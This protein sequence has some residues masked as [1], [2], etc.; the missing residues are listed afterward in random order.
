MRKPRQ[1]GEQPDGAFEGA[2][3]VSRGFDG[4][5]LNPERQLGVR[6][7]ARW[8]CIRAVGHPQPTRAA[9][10]RRK[11]LPE[12]PPSAY[13][14]AQARHTPPAARRLFHIASDDEGPDG[15]PEE[16]DEIDDDEL[17]APDDALEARTR[18]AQT[19]AHAL[20]ELLATEAGYLADLRALVHVY[21]AQLPTLTAR[22]PLNLPILSP[23]YS[24]SFFP[25]KPPKPAPASPTDPFS[26]AAAPA[27][28]RSP[29]A[30]SPKSDDPGPPSRL[31]E[32]DRLLAD[33]D[34]RTVARNAAQILAV[35]D[36][37][38]RMLSG[39]AAGV[40]VADAPD[41]IERAIVGVATLF[42]T[43]AALFNAYE[44]FCVGHFDAL[45]SVRRVQ[46]RHPAEWDAY[47]RRCAVLVRDMQERE[48]EEAVADEK[49]D[50][51][52]VGEGGGDVD[53][54]AQ[55]GAGVH[56]AGSTSSSS[57][58]GTSAYT[59]TQDSHDAPAPTPAP[60]LLTPTSAPPTKTSFSASPPAERPATPTL[61]KALY[62][63]KERA[64]DKP[65]RRLRRHSMGAL[66][67]RMR[68]ARSLKADAVAAA[69][70]LP[71]PPPQPRR[72]ST[73][74]RRAQGA[75]LQFMDYLIKPVQRICK[76]P[77][78]L[79]LLYASPKGQEREV[80]GADVVV[81]SAAQAMRHV[82]ALVD[83]AHAQHAQHTQSARV[84]AR[85]SLPASFSPPSPAS[86]PADAD[87]L[88]FARGA[89]P[90]RLAGALDVLAARG[91]RGVARG[92]VRAR[93]L[94][95]VL[96]DGGWC[97]LVKAVRGRYE[98]RHWFEVGKFAVH[99]AVDEDPFL[100]YSIR[101]YSA[102]GDFELA[103]ACAGEKRL[104]LAALLDA[105]KVEN[106]P[107]WAGTA[108]CSLGFG[109]PD[110]AISPV[111]DAPSMQI[112]PSLPTI[113]SIPEL[114]GAPCLPPVSA[115]LDLP[116][117]PPPP[118]TTTPIPPT[119]PAFKT[120][121]SS[122]LSMSARTLG[123]PPSRRSSAVS[124]RAFFNGADVEDGAVEVHRSALLARAEVDSA[125]A[126]VVSG[127]CSAARCWAEA[128]DE[129]LFM[130][131]WGVTTVRS[132][133][134]A[135]RSRLARR[136]SL[137]VRRRRSNVDLTAA[138]PLLEGLPVPAGGLLAGHATIRAPRTNAKW[139]KGKAALKVV[140]GGE[141]HEEAV[142]IVDPV[143]EAASAG[144]LVVVQSPDALLLPESPTLVSQCSSTTASHTGSRAAS[145][146]PSAGPSPPSQQQ[147]LSALAPSP[148]KRARSMV[149]NVRG[150]FLPAAGAPPPPVR[151]LSISRIPAALAPP[152]QSDAPSLDS[153]RRRWRE[154][155]RRRVR[156]S[157]NVHGLEGAASPSLPVLSR[158][159]VTVSGE[160]ARYTWHTDEA[161]GAGS[162]P[163]FG[164][165][166]SPVRRRS[167][168]A[169]A[170]SPAKLALALSPS[171]SPS[172]KQGP[173]PAPS[174]ADPPPR[175]MLRAL[176]S[177]LTRATGS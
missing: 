104:W 12:R 89:G 44:D 61:T 123:E 6:E 108:P 82:A 117:P 46:A 31:R 9:P 75:R 62:K 155:L 91:L 157:P 47:E 132:V 38:G 102:D 128:H 32:K 60:V 148:P 94:G 35:H 136:E 121:L 156:S 50:A 66:V 1:D 37:F 129:E 142:A 65:A 77:L 92:R 97:V 163:L 85:L 28:S 119:R 83:R 11:S 114:D 81:A 113:Q 34:V 29:K 80:G 177:T 20:Q 64:T 90:V 103:A 134:G 19:R 69:A 26:A 45:E 53:E 172:L 140:T 98:M 167:L 93:Y 109:M 24:S 171:Q 130:G 16:G 48:L 176:L 3:G 67:P 7:H 116:P 107:P 101:M 153:V 55:D 59:P 147:H 79:D 74:D 139:G 160:H 39:A 166:V 126:D 141:E 133:W 170:S 63:G 41:D 71:K 152:T 144:G 127:E 70:A 164:R 100:P 124:V 149:D 4:G 68:S 96:Y 99:D 54:K 110:A 106:P 14:L 95:A 151:A 87:P 145:P 76:Y 49:D 51:E 40:D 162:P 138:P 52:A 10:A 57:R 175:N 168:F 84:L 22:P 15:D 72:K 42:T 120:E 18:R 73:S 161:P 13:R 33:A 21:L 115:V 173:S 2:D 43:Q 112:P 118:P 36:A 5:S 135:A 131:A 159:R 88:A 154:S 125:L 25:A 86:A 56:R 174:V 158:A 146:G 27:K 105:Q 111:D 78:L 58:L 8:A 137:V 23:S 150:F 169:P 30:R 122:A 165:G 143:P 17:V